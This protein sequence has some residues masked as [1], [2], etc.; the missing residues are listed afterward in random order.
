MNTDFERIRQIFLEIVVQPATRWE[1]LLNEA[2]ATK[3]GLHR[4]VAV[5][6]QAHARGD[7]ILD[8]N[9]AGQAPTGVFES[10][11]ER[12]G[13]VIGPYKLLQQIGEGGMGVVW[14]AE[15]T[16]PVQ[17]KVAL[18]VIKPGMDSRQVVA[19]FEA[20]RQ[21]LAMMDHVNI[22]RVFDGGATES[23]RP[24]FVMELVHGVP[25]TTY[26]DDR[27]LTPRARLEL[28]VPVC[29]AIQHAH[30]KG[31]IHRDVKPS[32]VM[33]TLA[34]GKPVPKVIDFGVA[35]A[36]EQKLTERTLFTQCGAMVG[37]LEYMSPEQAE[38]SAL[39]IDTRSDIYSLG[40]LLYELL[41]GGTP[42]SHQRVKDTAPAEILRIIKEEEPPRPSMRLNDSGDALA[43]ISA[44]RHTEPARLAKLLRGELDWIVM[45]TLEKDRDRRYETANGLAA[46]VQRY[47]ADEQVHACPPSAWYHFRKLAR[48]NKRALALAACLLLMLA[49]VATSVGWVTRDREARRVEGERERSAR[50]AEIE[51]EV[52]RALADAQ[53]LQGQA[54][55]PEALAAAQR[56]RGLLAG[57]EIST[58]LRQRIDELESDLVT[59]LR[60]E[61]IHGRPVL[62]DYSTGVELDAGYAKVF[63]EYGIDIAVLEPGAAAERIR[64]RSIRQQLAMAL[65][66]WAGM[67]KRK[68]GDQSWKKL[69][70]IA[71]A[72]D[73]D[74]WRTC[75]RDAML[76]GDRPG[77]ERLTASVPIKRLSPGTLYLLGNALIEVGAL[78]KGV[79]LLRDAQQRY[80]GDLWLND[81]LGA[82]YTW[83][84]KGPHG[85]RSIR[86][87]PLGATYKWGLKEPWYNDALRYY[88]AA[89]AVRPDNYRLHEL[90]GKI[91]HQQKS[92]NAAVAAF[93]RAIEL[94]PDHWGAWW[95]RGEI[96]LGLGQGDRAL[97]DYSH[98]IALNPKAAAAWFNRG[99]TYL[100]L[101]QWD[102]ASADFS[103]ATELAPDNAEAHYWL[104]RALEKNHVEK[105]VREYK[106]TLRIDPRFTLA[107]I[108]LGNF[109]RVKKDVEGAI[110]EYTEAL[111]IAPGD[112][113]IHWCLGNVLC[114]K[115]DVKGAIRAYTEVI[116]L[117]EDRGAAYDRLAWLLATTAD[118][119]LRDPK[120]AL[121]LARKAVELEPMNG[122]WRN[123]LGLAHYRNGAWQDALVELNQSMQ[124]RNGGTG[125]D[126]FFL[127]MAHWQLNHRDQAHQWYGQAVVWLE[128]NA[129]QNEELRRFRAEARELLG[130]EP[131]FEKKKGR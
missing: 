77:L 125:E 36:T 101:K 108:N 124:L 88:A 15:Q 116:R 71:R 18:K 27:Q 95:E 9:Q 6:L 110:R 90:V 99:Y 81:A 12:P 31:I 100:E 75:F 32:N 74:E 115:N 67:R 39:G 30:Q 79:A 97:A 57:A 131:F 83:G 103:K 128:K 54:K 25:I 113:L 123:T 33:I 1:T 70:E 82:T 122:N 34:D 14:M 61:E 93:S 55:W 104:G 64:G 13:T 56:A 52:K 111:R 85:A 63:R 16:R 38:M 105:A 59:V 66:D 117:N 91:L 48:R 73:P 7:G 11:S 96:Y 89:L 127:A 17:R 10:L 46:D 49:V 87:G 28:F 45:K 130:I 102:K 120:K 3:P 62:P 106:T 92:L 43:S 68:Q 60:L 21:A 5:L 44:Q 53:H 37:T 80:P 23:G 26:C 112:D 4:Q 29:R 84:L 51:R 72:A 129:A 114:D 126:F 22:A 2:C 107:H 19:R 65:D 118:E 69:V 40:V 42:L 24:Y 47:L 86:A 8:R 76:R 35:K 94:K 121:A 41:T 20:E 50:A 119:K 109:L 78:D 58:E 98:V